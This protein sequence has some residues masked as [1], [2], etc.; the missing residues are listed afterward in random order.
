MKTKKKLDSNTVLIFITIA[1]FV[2]MY[3]VGCVIY[4]DKGFGN[5]QTFLNVLIN[6]AGLICVTCG[7]TCVMLTGGIDISVGSVIAMDCMLLVFGMTEWHMGAVPMV[8]LVLVIGLVF[9]A[10]QGF[11]VG[12]LEIQPF[13]V[14]MAGMFFARGMTAVICSGQ[15]SITEADN[16]LFYAWANSKINLPEFLGK[17]NKHGKI[18]APYIRP[19]VLIALIVLVLIFLML[20]YTKFGRNLYAVGG[21][22]TSATMMGLNV[23]KTRMLSHILSSFLCSIGGILY[24]LNTMSGSVNQ[25]KGLEMDAIASAVIGGTLLTG[26]VGNVIGSLFGV[27]INGTITVLVNTNGKL[28]SSWANIATAALLCVFIILQSIFALVKAQRNK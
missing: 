15:I 7:M 27:L 14:T 16:P 28:L 19:T 9:G 20:K 18:V 11:L 22:Q 6:N 26:G 5:L 3:A 23:K 24:C 4:A 10:V 25:A 17:A 21:N 2:F 1:L 8:I 12:Y 13:I